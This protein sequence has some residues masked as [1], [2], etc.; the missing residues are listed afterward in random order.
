M[1]PNRKSLFLTIPLA[2]VLSLVAAWPCAAAVPDPTPTD[3]GVLP[4][5][6]HKY[7][8]AY[9]INANG[10]VVGES[11]EADTPYP[12]PFIWQNGVMTQLPLPEGF[13]EGV[14]IS[15]NDAG[16]VVGYCKDWDSQYQAFLWTHGAGGWVGTA[17]GAPTVSN[18]EDPQQEITFINSKAV[19]INN[20]GQIFVMA[21]GIAYEG[22]T[23]DISVGAIWQDGTWSFLTDSDGLI[24]GASGFLSKINDNGQVL[25]TNDNSNEVNHDLWV[26][27][28]ETAIMLV[29]MIDWANLNNSGQIV[30][31]YFDDVDKQSKNF[32]YDTETKELNFS[33]ASDA[34]YHLVTINDKGQVLV[35]YPT[36]EL[37]IT[38]FEDWSPVTASVKSLCFV[39]GSVEPRSLNFNANGE[40]SGHCYTS[41]TG[42]KQLFYA[43]E[44]AGVIPLDGFVQ[45][46]F[47]LDVRAM[48]DSGVIIGRAQVEDGGAHAV[49]WGVP[50]VSIDIFIDP[51][52][53][54]PVNTQITS[55]AF[56]SDSQTPDI[57]TATWDWGDN[58][59]SDGTIEKENEIVIGV[60]S[61]AV[62]GVYTV[63]LKIF[64][65][66]RDLLNQAVYQYVVV[67]DPT[68]GF[69]TGG[70]WFNSPAGAYKNDPSLAGQATFGFVSRYKKGAT[71]PTGN[72][73]LEFAAGELH[74]QSTSYDWLVVK[75]SNQASFKG[76]G[77]ING[78]GDYKFMLWAG[79]GETDTFRIR[80]W[81]EDE[82]TAEEINIYDNGSDQ[83]IDGGSIVIHAK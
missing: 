12:K 80:I 24:R 46:G 34:G 49:L 50:P 60:H 40:V 1:K 21:R 5:Y 65:S 26:W 58:S 44:E 17:L 30:G 74:F 48:N 56:L 27:D 55:G 62:P 61:Y 67:Y 3:L 18:P 73:A 22:E 53:P 37:G 75:G 47:Y 33:L 71:I 79:D 32:T 64:N 25:F 63:A 19:S 82:V 2:M 69:V 16:Q 38:S 42:E 23:L 81:E 39:G 72:T 35:L 8:E 83:P 6:G 59:T 51:S 9:A 13:S 20:V 29:K 45:D 78:L 31:R 15:I 41:D 54:V 36:D 11:Y 7:S 14:A 57:L 76:S 43:S 77:T 68:A 66:Y 28:G 10:Q 52:S 70:G 4:I